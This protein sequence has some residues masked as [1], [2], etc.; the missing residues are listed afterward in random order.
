V[1]A[2]VVVVGKGGCWDSRR[3]NY[4]TWIVAG[5]SPDSTVWQWTVEGRA[6]TSGL[7]ATTTRVGSKQIGTVTVAEAEAE[8]PE[9]Q[10]ASECDN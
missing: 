10:M 1:V 4:R 3:E 9:D 8:A 7:A 6:A 5:C 2:V